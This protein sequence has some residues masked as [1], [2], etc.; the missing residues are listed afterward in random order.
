L[1]HTQAAAPL[2]LGGVVD[3]AHERTLGA[4][5]IPGLLSLLASGDP[6]A[7]VRGLDAAAPDDLPPVA[8][9]HFAFD[10]MVGSG[11]LLLA[12]AAW[13]CIATRAGARP[14]SKALACALGAAGLLALVALEAGWVVTEM[15]RQPWIARGLQRTTDAV[16]IAAGLD[17]AFAVFS[18]IYVLLGVTCWWLVARLGRS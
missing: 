18:L 16:T 15:G 13:W 4:V 17:V 2:T 3:A 8:P 5:E 14:V 1:F 7:T 9:V 12:F 6:R 11:T 10:L